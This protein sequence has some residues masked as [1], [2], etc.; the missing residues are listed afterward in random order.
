MEKKVSQAL[1]TAFLLNLAFFLVET[2]GGLLTGSVAILAD[3]IH[4][5][6]DTIA[7]GF[8]LWLEKKALSKR[9]QE[10]SYGYARYSVF[11]QA[12]SALLILMGSVFIVHE[13]IDRIQNPKAAPLGWG[14]L[15][16]AVLGVLVNGVA[17]F[18]LGGF[19]KHAHHDHD[20]HHH[21]HSHGSHSHGSERLFS[22]H[23]LEDAIGWVFVLLGAVG[24]M[25][26]GWWWIDPVL[27]LLLSAFVIF[28]VIRH[29]KVVVD[30]L[31]QKTPT[32]FRVNEFYKL[33]AKVPNL[34]SI[35]DLHVWTLDGHKNI[36]SLHAVVKPGV[37]AV[38]ISQIKKSLQ[39][40][41]SNWGHFHM[42][43][44]TEYSNQEC[45]DN[46]DDPS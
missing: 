26:T 1:K 33:V 23:L 45:R 15:L 16:L 28:N 43:I 13:C 32:Q 4:D 21:G 19:Q 11:S 37:D 34:E 40:I 14:M 22:L 17:A 24:I 10:H 46:C 25:A 30:V 29:S 39:E 9:D 12:L 31:L 44:E 7:L 8:S 6:G 36:L 18:R 42:T 5:L 27:G 35:H 20:H 3:A 41:V 2:V 38:G